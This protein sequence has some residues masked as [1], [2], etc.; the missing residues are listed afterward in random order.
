MSKEKN[1][2]NKIGNNID[3]SFSSK[4]ITNFTNKYKK[5]IY[6]IYTLND[7]IFQKMSIYEEEDSYD[8]WVYDTQICKDNF[9]FN[10]K[11]KNNIFYNTISSSNRFNSIKVR[12]NEN[13]KTFFL[14]DNVFIDLNNK[15]SNI[16]FSIEEK[17]DNLLLNEDKNKNEN[18]DNLIKNIN[19]FSS[20]HKNMKYLHKNKDID[21]NKNNNNNIDKKFCIKKSK[22]S[23]KSKKKES[24]NK[25]NDKYHIH[26]RKT[27][28]LVIDLSNSKN[29][30][31]KIDCIS[32][33]IVKM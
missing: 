29:K 20:L 2:I 19:T 17:K 14:G 25:E 31:L 30:I 4:E 22:F 3:I 28:D 18:Y 13:K 16:N 33:I 24:D 7:N 12:N 23:K 5:Q 32:N 15:K 1:I 9:F 11:N 27:T 26:D 6:N 21:L 8:S 10:E